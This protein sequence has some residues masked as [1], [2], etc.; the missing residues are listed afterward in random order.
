MY[1]TVKYFNSNISYV[2]D[3]FFYFVAVVVVIMTIII[4]IIIIS[5]S[6]SRVILI[7]NFCP[8]CAALQ[9]STANLEF[10]KL[11]FKLQMQFLYIKKGI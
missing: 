11:L 4:I 7:Y 6:S 2:F 1:F 10:K 3:I 8:I 5:S 9:T